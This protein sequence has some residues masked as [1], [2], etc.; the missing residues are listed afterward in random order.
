M[1]NSIGLLGL[2]LIFSVCSSAGGQAPALSLEI[3]T[4]HI[5][6]QQLTAR[7]S[8]AFDSS[9][10]PHV[11]ANNVR[12]TGIEFRLF[13]RINNNW[14]EQ[15]IGSSSIWGGGLLSRPRIAID[16]VT[17]RGWISGW[18]TGATNT[19]HKGAV[20]WRLD[21]MTTGPQMFNNNAQPFRYKF[22]NAI[23]GG[24]VEFDPRFP[25][26]IIMGSHSGIWYRINANG[27]V[28]AQ[29]RHNPGV[30]IE[31]MNFRISAVGNDVV[32]HFISGGHQ[33][34]PSGYQNSARAGQGRVIY[35]NVPPYGDQRFDYFHPALGID[36][37][38]PN[39]AYMAWQSDG[40]GTAPNDSFK[41]T[42]KNLYI[43]VWDGTAMVADP[44]NAIMVDTNVLGKAQLNGEGNDRAPFEFAPAP[45]GGAW[46]AYITAG[47]G[48]VSDQKLRLVY[49]NRNGEVF[50]PFP[51]QSDPRLITDNVTWAVLGTDQR[52][53]L[54]IAWGIG[55]AVFYQKYG[56]AGGPGAVDFPSISFDSVVTFDEG[57]TQ[58]AIIYS[59]EENILFKADLNSTGQLDNFGTLGDQ[60]TGRWN[61]V[62][63]EDLRG[64]GA[65]QAF[66]IE[67]PE[68]TLGFQE[69]DAQKNAQPFQTMKTAG[70]HLNFVGFFDIDGDGTK[71]VV[72]KNALNGEV[73]F[74]KIDGITMDKV[75]RQ[76][77][78]RTGSGWRPFGVADL[79]ASGEANLLWESFR[80]NTFP[81]VHTGTWFIDRNGERSWRELSIRDKAWVRFAVLDLDGN[82]QDDI[83]FLHPPTRSF[84]V[85]RYNSNTRSLEATALGSSSSTDWTPVGATR[86]TLPEIGEVGAIIWVNFST[87]DVGL[88]RFNSE[89]ERLWVPNVGNLQPFFTQ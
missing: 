28:V 20:A 6:N 59:E 21:N 87:G 41:T 70:R 18:L 77:I 68:R 12:Q 61:F 80:T 65:K 76:T 24:L 84:K 48:R 39:V 58:T 36:S 43:N 78:G 35:A 54:H 38:D 23:W 27:G 10:Q 9:G 67:L 34:E 79:D 14:N 3:P 42:P 71:D 62:G 69:F 83:L 66:W 5:G 26:E 2:T 75:S 46:L 8:I 52:G 17:D 56:V 4:E 50:D 63:I 89:L 85:A 25:G 49:I 40:L 64:D 30:S 15:F 32:Y 16:P 7:G 53:D 86:V 51:G 29:G 45:G 19:F 22:A 31:K 82:G 74:W 44:N 88:W 57:N 81:I 11:V 37:S 33:P 60:R 13:S 47:N 1:K 73:E 72:W 55:N